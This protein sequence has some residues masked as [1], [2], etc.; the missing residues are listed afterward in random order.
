[1]WINFPQNS[2]AGES[3]ITSG[4]EG[5]REMTSPLTCRQPFPSQQLRTSFV[6]VYPYVGQS[7]ATSIK[8]LCRLLENACRWILNHHT[9]LKRSLQQVPY[10]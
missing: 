3:C 8:L 9:G 6:A 2:R 7:N 1:M 5:I 10:P 4:L